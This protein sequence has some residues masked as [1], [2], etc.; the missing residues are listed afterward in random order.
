MIR[1]EVD[2]GYLI[3]TANEDKSNDAVVEAISR[4]EYGE[5]RSI[6]S[7]TFD[8]EKDADALMDQLAEALCGKWL[9]DDPGEFLS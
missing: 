6:T 8:T 9:S 7:I 1:I 4:T 3:V 5:E 2:N